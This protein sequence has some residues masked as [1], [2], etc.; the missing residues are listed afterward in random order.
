MF[1]R[2]PQLVWLSLVLAVCTS[3]L[4]GC[5]GIPR[6]DPSGERLFIC[7]R[8]QVPP[9]SPISGNIT[10]PPVY[11]DP[12]FPQPQ[13]ANASGIF[14]Q[15]SPISAGLVPPPPQDRM[16]ISPQ[17]V[18][19]PVGSEVVL[20]AGLCTSENY[21]LT[22]TKTEWLIARNSAGEFVELGGKGWC[23][24]PLLPWN[25]PKKIDNTYA[26]GYSA[27]V[28]LRITRG[29][30]DITDDVEVQPGEAWATITSPVEG[31]SHITAVAPEVVDWSGRRAN[32]TIY[33]VD[34]QWTFPPATISSSGAQV[35]TTTVRRQTDG[36][37][38]EGWL[39]RYEVVSATGT[40][41]DTQ[42]GQVQEVPTD[43][44]GQASIDVT[45]T[46][47]SGAITR[48]NTQIIRPPLFGGS[49]MP[50]LLIA[51]GTSLI[52]WTDGGTPYVPPV[53]NLG[54]GTSIPDLAD[55]P[56]SP[57][58][59]P[60]PR[61]VTPP[62]VPQSPELE[63][64]IRAPGEVQV[65]GEAR[66]EVVVR[67][68]GSGRAT[69]VTLNDRFDEGLSHLRD[70]QR[71]LNIQKPLPDIA[72]NTSHT[73]FISF[74]VLRAGNLCHDVTVTCRE[75]SQAQERACVNAT[76][77]LPQRRAGFEVRKIGPEGKFI[78]VGQTATFTL[79][80]KNTGEVPLTN[81]EVVDEYDRELSPKPTQQ[82]YEIIN[83]AIFWRF[84]R[85][86]VNQTIRLDV[87]CQCLAPKAEA[88]STA[89]VT[90]NSGTE[91]LTS[92][93]RHC[94]EILQGRD[95]VPPTNVIPQP[96][97]VVPQPG[98]GTP[99]N[100]VVPGGLLLDIRSLSANPARVGTAARYEIVVRNNS[101]ASDRQ[102]QL[103]VSFP[104]GIA[105]NP[106]SL[107]S[108]YNVQASLNLNNE[109]VVDPINEI[110]PGERLTFT[111]QANVNQQGVGNVTAQLSSVNQVQPV[112]KSVRV[113]AI[114]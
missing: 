82:G 40:I 24:D 2:S 84:Q 20:K 71:Y 25:K 94:I 13:G 43:V 46:S 111:V 104:Q 7:S 51:N 16:S 78:E 67:N 83:N 5:A 4:V 12:V 45:P 74:N 110:R 95:V 60:T 11:T 97:D 86:E 93:D 3:I 114:R 18:L 34:V 79:T 6:I 77:P 26:V 65:N 102:V 29:T 107:Q 47:G 68:R 57:T 42:P 44:N 15:A 87:N 89:Q 38:L 17:R 108:N 59:T 33:W 55:P 96:G 32:A 91:A 48:I 113:D 73:E 70:T 69:G 52:N 54:S 1:A 21:L 105:P 85:L 90:A 53:D 58:P 31:T 30:A 35:L 63:L 88:C 28:P 22:K 10:A 56:I 61:D 62:V 49:D 81:V 98:T 112:Q 106:L 50:R 66:F 103:R 8:D 41:D 14:P 23:R 36:T 39:V 64:Q 80:I 100:S 9:V 101:T 99:Q 27:E 92:T 76:Q 37:P 72:P 75:G 19:A 109:L